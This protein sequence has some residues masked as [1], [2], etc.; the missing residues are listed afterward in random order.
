MSKSPMTMLSSIWKSKGHS[1]RPSRR[2]R[3]LGLGHLVKRVLIVQREP[4]EGI[5]T[6]TGELT[7]EQS[8]SIGDAF[9]PI[10]K[11]LPPTQPS[12]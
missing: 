2:P 8:V 12:M 7:E 11:L 6:W 5:Y 9:L 10:A 1:I 4:R 3:V